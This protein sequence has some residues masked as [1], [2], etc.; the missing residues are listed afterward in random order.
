MRCHHVFQGQFQVW[1][2]TKGGTTAAVRAVLGVQWGGKPFLLM[3][4][5]ITQWFRPRVVSWSE[6]QIRYIWQL[7]LM[8]E[9]WASQSQGYSFDLDAQCDCRPGLAGVIR[10]G[11]VLLAWLVQP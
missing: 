6:I 2:F 3:E 4:V 1:T 9:V 5:T 11:V 10:S 8:L 7:H